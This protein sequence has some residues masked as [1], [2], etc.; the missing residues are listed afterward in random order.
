M[1]LLTNH[2]GEI[3]LSIIETLEA[4]D[5]LFMAL[6]GEMVGYLPKHFERK[7]RNGLLN[8]FLSIGNTDAFD[9]VDFD[10][11]EKLHC[12]IESTG[13]DAESIQLAT[14]S[15]TLLGAHILNC[16]AD[17]SEKWVDSLTE[18]ENLVTSV[19]R[20]VDKLGLPT[21]VTD[22]NIGS[23]NRYESA[24]DNPA[25]KGCAIFEIEIEVE[26]LFDRPDSRCV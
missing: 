17:D 9:E 12:C 22:W 20:G 26:H 23:I 4:D 15:Y 25:L 5:E 2:S 14:T 8:L 6:N 24:E 11:R 19:L 18:F 7:V 16:N 1:T 3:F 21:S 10:D 13:A